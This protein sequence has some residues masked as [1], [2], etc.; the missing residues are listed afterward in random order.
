MFGRCHSWGVIPQTD[1][2][3]IPKSISVFQF[4]HHLSSPYPLQPKIND[5][6]MTPKETDGLNQRRWKPTPLCDVADEGIV[7]REGGDGNPKGQGGRSEA[8]GHGDAAFDWKKIPGSQTFTFEHLG[9]HVLL[10]L[11][12]SS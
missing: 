7:A 10:I 2:L 11:E 1:E 5:K 9:I 3:P 12:I 4:P 6:P 8:A